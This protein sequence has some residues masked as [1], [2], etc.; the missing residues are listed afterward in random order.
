M[1]TTRIDTI[2][3]ATSVQLAPE[4][5]LVADLDCRQSDAARRRSQQLIAEQRKAKEVGDIGE[6]EKHGVY[7]GHF[8]I[9]PFNGE[10]VPDLGG[11]LYPHGLRHGRHHERARA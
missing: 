10:K 2:Y 4:H 6:I 5:P 8:A 7:T 11:E 9:N 3:G 1:F